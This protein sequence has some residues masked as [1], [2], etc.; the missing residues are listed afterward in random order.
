MPKRNENTSVQVIKVPRGEDAPDG[1]PRDEQGHPLETRQH[2]PLTEQ[3]QRLVEAYTSPGTKGNA[4]QSAL[5]AGYADRYARNHAHALVKKPH[6]LAAINARLMTQHRTT[7]DPQV[8]TML[9]RL[10]KM[11]L[12]KVGD[13]YQYDESYPGGMRPKDLSQIDTSA[14]KRIVM[15]TARDGGV[16]FEI[17][18]YDA[19]RA[20][21]LY[22]KA[23]G[24][25]EQEDP[26]RG[27]QINI[28]LFGQDQLGGTQGPKLV[29]PDGD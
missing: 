19:Q 8:E 9:R 1:E 2:Q 3:Q 10:E 25:F 13:F 11:A 6:I 12:A 7:N 23:K 5:A 26:G 17:E 20:M 29:N 15:K 4:Y 18:T 22:F 14:V 16:T 27:K 28:N 24:V 21:E